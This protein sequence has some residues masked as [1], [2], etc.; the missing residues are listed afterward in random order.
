MCMHI[1]QEYG[2]Y[3]RRILQVACRCILPYKTTCTSSNL[4]CDVT[5]L[6]IYIIEDGAA[7]YEWQWIIDVITSSRVISR[8]VAH[9]VAFGTSHVS[10][11]CLHFA[12]GLPNV[13]SD[14]RQNFKGRTRIAEQSSLFLWPVVPCAKF[15]CDHFATTNM[16]AEWNFH[17]IWV[18]MEKPFVKWA[19]GLLS[20]LSWFH[21]DV[22]KWKHFPCYWSS[23]RGIHRSPVN[24]PH[25]SPV[26]RSFDVLFDLHPNKR[27]SKQ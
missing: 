1:N 24:P 13:T 15:H 27:L 17:R 18:T 25:K 10:W 11:I 12:N 9:R 22:I 7:L 16:R 3:P 21:G 5:V 4:Q 2:L 20:Y 14:Y 26:T 8:A 19:P 23:V 6:Y